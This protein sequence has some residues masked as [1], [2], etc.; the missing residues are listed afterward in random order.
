MNKLKKEFIEFGNYLEINGK[1]NNHTDLSRKFYFYYDETENIRLFRNKEKGFNN[2]YDVSFSLGGIVFEKNILTE[3]HEK[4][5][6][7]L[8]VKDNMKEIKAKFIMNNK[9]ENEYFDV[10]NSKKLTTLLEYIIDS[11]YKVHFTYFNPLFYS[12]VDIVDSLLDGHK[13]LPIGFNTMEQFGS[14]L[15]SFLYNYIYINIDFWREKFYEIG[16]PSLSPES[17][18]KLYNLIFE[19]LKHYPTQNIKE[20]DSLLQ[21]LKNADSKRSFYS[22]QIDKHIFIENFREIYMFKPQI[23]DVSIHEFDNEEHI[24][25]YIN[26]D[27]INKYNLN[28][29]WHE[30][31]NYRTIQ[32]S[33]CII[34]LINRFIK[35]I[36]RYS[37]NEINNDFVDKKNKG[38]SYMSVIK[39]HELLCEILQKS[40]YKE[41]AFF[42]IV[43]DNETRIKFDQVI[44]I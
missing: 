14:R 35:Y 25:E 30:S 18:K 21:L 5:W 24:K 23:F 44:N 12:I 3:K 31:E 17:L 4:L 7:D 42:M 13:E 6:K 2:D 36:E 19:N 10:I 37:L 20:R 39:N 34:Y 11:N 33:D 26:N 9:K 29:S 43:S 1:K 38:Q 16:Y 41:K 15:K 32:I 28:I 40:Y 8:A 22:E 27:F